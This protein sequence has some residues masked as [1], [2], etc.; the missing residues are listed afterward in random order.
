MKFAD[1]EQS[2]EEFSTQHADWAFAGYDPSPHGIHFALG[3][4]HSTSDPERLAQAYVR[5]V[6]IFE[7][8]FAPSDDG[9]ALFQ[10]IYEEHHLRQ[11]L[12]YGG[13]PVTTRAT[14]WAGWSETEDAEERRAVTRI[15]PRDL[16]Y[17]KL[18]LDHVG[19][20]SGVTDARGSMTFLINTT[21]PAVLQLY[22]C[23]ELLVLAEDPALPRRL[24]TEFSDWVCPDCRDGIDAALA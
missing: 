17:E 7:A 3:D 13:V 23:R 11:V 19:N 18:C 20:D 14:L 15:R 2:V 8:T 24:L 9:F 4:P 6:K 1:I 16:N 10:D 21:T 5:A 12:V 22:D